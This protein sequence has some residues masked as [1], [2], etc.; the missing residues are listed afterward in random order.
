MSKL[1]RLPQENNNYLLYKRWHLKKVQL[2]Q[3][4]K[5][6]HINYLT[7]FLNHNQKKD[8][9][10]IKVEEDHYY[11]RLCILTKIMD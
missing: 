9:T 11:N 3:K 8:I 7:A 10:A 4:M 2:Y 1:T 5:H 6:N